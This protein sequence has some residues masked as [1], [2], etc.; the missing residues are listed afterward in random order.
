MLQVTVAP[1]TVVTITNGAAVPV[2][3]A[4]AYKAWVKDAVNWVVDAVAIVTIC[5]SKNVAVVKPVSLMV[6]PTTKLLAHVTVRLLLPSIAIL[7]MVATLSQV[8]VPT[9]VNE[10]C[11]LLKKFAA[12]TLVVKV[13][14][15][16]ATAIL[17]TVYDCVVIS[18]NS[19][20]RVLSRVP[21]D[22]KVSAGLK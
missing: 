22:R 14:T 21:P 17:L 4:E 5:A 10:I 11:W 1:D 18:Q 8:A 2:S 16:A 6:C 15:F 12:L 7:L 9:P 20:C 13:R 3:T 19:H